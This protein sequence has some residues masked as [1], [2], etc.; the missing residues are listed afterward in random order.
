MQKWQQ[1]DA[2]S[3]EDWGIAVER[4]ACHAALNEENVESLLSIGSPFRVIFLLYEK[5]ER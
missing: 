1:W 3:E 4:E 2:A 5:R